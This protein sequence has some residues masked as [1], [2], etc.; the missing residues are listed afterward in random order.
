MIGQ[1]PAFG[2]ELPEGRLVV[3]LQSDKRSIE[4]QIFFLR[5][6]PRSAVIGNASHPSGM[7]AVL[8]PLRIHARPHAVATRV[9]QRRRSSLENPAVEVRPDSCD[10]RRR[11]P[12]AGP[13]SVRDRTDR[14]LRESRCRPPRRSDRRSVGAVGME[15][16]GEILEREKLR[17]ASCRR[18][19]QSGDA[20]CQLVR[21]QI[22]RR[23]QLERRARIRGSR[24]RRLRALVMELDP[25]P[26]MISAAACRL[27][28]A[29]AG[30]RINGA[31]RTETHRVIRSRT[32][33]RTG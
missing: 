26:V 19:A 4:R 22:A 18:A 5:R 32:S 10:V 6:P 31:R 1:T 7:R 20:S 3:L 8:A 17:S 14:C 23:I 24:R 30:V 9:L 33:V 16:D 12:S 13:T 15:D 11:P 28:R 29:V 27:D 21:R 25:A 2:G